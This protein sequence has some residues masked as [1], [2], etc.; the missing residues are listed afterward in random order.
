VEPIVL[1]QP[2]GRPWGTPNLSPFCTKLETYLRMAEVP[3]AV[4]AA[5]FRKAPKGKIPFVTIDDKLVGDSQLV[6]EELER[7][8]GDRALDA[9]L[10]ARDRAIARTVRR[11]LDEA[12]YF[13]GMYFRWG[14]DDGY[15]ILAPEFKKVLPAPFRVLM[16]VIRRGVKKSLHKQGTGRH[17]PDEVAGIGAADLDAL[18][19]L[20][21]DQDFLFGK[22]PRTVDAS[23]FA[24]IEGIAGF[25]LDSPLKR[26]LQGKPNL[27]AYRDRVRA[28]WWKDLQASAS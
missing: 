22:A 9:G 23:V 4:V 18:S 7:R 13:V 28:R 1:H 20:L 10:G 17:T 6:I 2:P 5:D 27:I 24:F 12:F 15:A 11:M 19:E 3:H 8:L 16:P 21:G 26:H 14:T 25:P